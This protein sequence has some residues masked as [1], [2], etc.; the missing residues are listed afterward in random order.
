M[1]KGREGG[2]GEWR[3][4]GREG[5]RGE[6]RKGSREGGR[7]EWRKGGREAKGNGAEGNGDGGVKNYYHNYIH[8]S[9]VGVV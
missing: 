5:G 3:K 9:V 1:E 8:D 4:G 6:W 7:G 2:R